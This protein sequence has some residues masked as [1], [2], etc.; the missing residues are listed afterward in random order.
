[1]SSQQRILLVEDE[2]SLRE[3]LKLNLELE[4]Y[5]VVTA[6][7][8]TKA[9]HTYNS[10]HFDLVLLDI[11]LPEMDGLAVCESIRLKDD[12]IP[13]LFLSAKSTPADRV[14]GLKRGGDDY[15]VKPFNLEEL[16]LRVNI[17]LSKSNKIN[18]KEPVA[19][20]Y[21]F[22]GNQIDFHGYIATTFTG[23]K[24]TLTK[25]EVL[26]LKLLIENKR[27]VVTRE[28]ILQ[29]AWGYDVYPNTR[30]IDNFILNFRKYFEKDSKEPIHFFSVRGVGYKFNE[31]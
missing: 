27:E 5:Q 29:T 13:I 31:K 9:V 15:L 20:I 7:T 17:L 21:H 14:A 10:E 24:I 19:D 1:M 28:H 26:L 25:K 11:M 23:E 3:A 18:A 4:G 16:L 8:G 30:T 6:D 12:R 22:G 2:Q